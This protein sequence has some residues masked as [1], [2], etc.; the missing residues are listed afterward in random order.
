M[1]IWRAIYRFDFLFFPS[2]LMHPPRALAPDAF[3][4]VPCPL[5]YPVHVSP[6]VGCEP[7]AVASNYEGVNLPLPLLSDCCFDK[8]LW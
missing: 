7:S 1:Y 4:C 6:R 5:L 2:T 3:L 8:Y